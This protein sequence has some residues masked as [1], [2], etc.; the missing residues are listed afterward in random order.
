MTPKPMMQVKTLLKIP[1]V[2]IRHQLGVDWRSVRH[3][4]GI[5]NR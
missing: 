5:T 1:E 4:I 3:Q 2:T